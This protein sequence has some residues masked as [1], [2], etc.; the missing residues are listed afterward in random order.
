VCSSDLKDQLLALC[1]NVVTSFPTL[2]G[3]DS[4][5]QLITRLPSV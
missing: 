5:A 2:G 4:V 1:A 3:D